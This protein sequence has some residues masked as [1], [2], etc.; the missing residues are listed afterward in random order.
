MRGGGTVP[1]PL[2]QCV[3]VKRLGQCDKPEGYCVGD[4][5]KELPLNVDERDGSEDLK[6]PDGNDTCSAPRGRGGEGK[7]LNRKN[8]V[9]AVKIF[10][11]VCL[12][13]DGRCRV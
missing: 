2:T 3:T 8:A 10:S 5:Q 9:F 4:K 12:T 11:R 13:S 7:N 1:A 6:Q